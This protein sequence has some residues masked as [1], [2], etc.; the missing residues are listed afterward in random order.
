MK[1]TSP[2]MTPESVRS[3]LL[4]EELVESPTRVDGQWFAYKPETCTVEDVQAV[5]KLVTK[6]YGRPT[7][8]YCDDRLVVFAS[9]PVAPALEPETVAKHCPTCQCGEP[10]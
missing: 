1:T 9:G 2:P 3:V 6:E 7:Q 5:L 8:F 10:Q 4:A